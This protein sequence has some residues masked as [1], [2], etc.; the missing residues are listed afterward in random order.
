MVVR[1]RAEETAVPCSLTRTVEVLGERWTFFIVR[2]ALAG[3]TRFAEFRS[4]LGVA[5]DVLTCRLATMVDAGV[6]VR[7]NYQEPGQRARASY[8]LTESGRQ[9]ALIIG[10]LQQWGDEHVPCTQEPT[11]VCRTAAGRPVS[12]RFV[13][14]QGEILTQDEV[15]LERTASHPLR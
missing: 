6:M 9:L 2:E 13:D 1:D 10:A 12:V 4:T 11:I 8:H 3:A 5:S 15:R 7:R 14:D